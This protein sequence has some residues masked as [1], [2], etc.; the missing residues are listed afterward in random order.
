M[1]YMYS[2]ASYPTG[3]GASSS[4][5]NSQGQ[6]RTTQITTPYA[7]TP[8]NSIVQVGIYEELFDPSRITVSVGSTVRWTNVG[9]KHHTV[10]SDTRDWGSGDLAPGATYSY[11]FTRPGNYPYRCT[12]NSWELSGTVS[13]K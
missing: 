13:V 3:Y 9:R 12:L 8:A 10:T 11:T 4:Y 2:S 6:L 1:M 5:G 7:T